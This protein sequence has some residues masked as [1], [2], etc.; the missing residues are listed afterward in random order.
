MIINN[1]IL[2]T[3]IFNPW[4]IFCNLRFHEVYKTTFIR[5]LIAR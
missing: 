3:Y 5:K 2:D 4:K 1:Y